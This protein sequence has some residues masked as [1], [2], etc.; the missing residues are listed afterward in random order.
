MELA[1]LATGT[2][3]DGLILEGGEVKVKTLTAGVTDHGALSGLADDDHT[4]YPLIAGR[5][6]GQSITGG[7][8]ANNELIFNSTT[9]GT[10]GTITCNDP[11]RLNTVATGTGTNFLIIESNVVKQKN[12]TV[13]VTD[14]GALTGLADDDH[15]QY[16]NDSRGDTRYYPRTDHLNLS[17]GASSANFPI[18]LNAAGHVDPT[19]TNYHHSIH[20][21]ALQPGVTVTQTAGTD[22]LGAT[23]LVPTELNGYTVTQV[24]YALTT[25]TSTTGSLTIGFRQFNTTNTSSSTNNFSVTFNGSDVRKTASPGS[26]VVSG[27]YYHAEVNPAVGGTLD[28]TVQGLLIT[29]ILKK[30]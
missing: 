14:H 4:Q 19:M 24:D 3:T 5:S 2:G 18:K 6:G 20:L 21:I 16:H 11:L 9:S 10:K 26:T 25:N 8:A 22:F 15:T 27:H 13:G 30:V 17:L 7:T 23:F 12:V 28:G 1:N 29:L